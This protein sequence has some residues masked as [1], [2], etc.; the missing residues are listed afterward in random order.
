LSIRSS[1][2]SRRRSDALS[3]GVAMADDPDH[4]KAEAQLDQ[5]LHLIGQ[6]VTG[7]AELDN[8]L[9]HLLA[10]LAG[11]RPKAAGIIYYALDAFSTRL[12]V[13]KGL[14]QHKLRKGRDRT[15]LLRFLD[16]LHQLGTTRN[17]I[18]HA[19]YQMVY[20][21]QRRKTVIKKMVFRSARKAPHQETIAQ[22][23]ELETHVRL[24]QDA[25]L[26]LNIYRWGPRSRSGPRR[27]GHPLSS[28]S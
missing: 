28:L 19:V 3:S 23:G 12:A 14:A 13:I 10:R 11:C 20:M 22:T 24:L 18:V 5:I 15:A 16:R 1:T 21:P 9:I 25:R 17:D 4:E 6:V 8:S 7:W 27:P 2:A 26:W